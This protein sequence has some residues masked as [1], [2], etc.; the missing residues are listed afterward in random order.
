MRGKII[1]AVLPIALILS[2]IFLWEKS[3]RLYKTIELM[4]MIQELYSKELPDELSKDLAYLHQAKRNAE[5]QA[6]QQSQ[7]SNAVQTPITK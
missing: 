3:T 4:N 2:G 1:Y 7:K 5:V 6:A